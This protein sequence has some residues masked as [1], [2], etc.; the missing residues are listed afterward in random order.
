MRILYTIGLLIGVP[1]AFV[2]FIFIAI[3]FEDFMRK[4]FGKPPIALIILN[5]VCWIYVF[6]RIAW[7]QAGKWVK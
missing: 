6:A 3:W 5:V 1:L 4:R 7:E 2:A